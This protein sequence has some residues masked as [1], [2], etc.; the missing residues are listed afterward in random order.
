[1]N[2]GRITKNTE[3]NEMGPF[4]EISDKSE[5]RNPELPTDSQ[6]PFPVLCMVL[7]SIGQL[8]KLR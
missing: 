1:M 3:E 7:Q 6:V 4:D 5:I 2:D 8:I